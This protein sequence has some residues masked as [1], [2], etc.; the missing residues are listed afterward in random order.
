MNNL[1]RVDFTQR[2]R[3]VISV[4]KYVRI[5]RGVIK[6]RPNKRVSNHRS[7]AAALRGKKGA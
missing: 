4:D 5:S 2:K 6:L 7:I 1:I 3:S